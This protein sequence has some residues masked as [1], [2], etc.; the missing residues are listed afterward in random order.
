MNEDDSALAGI[1]TCSRSLNMNRPKKA[2]THTPR[3]TAQT[4]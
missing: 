4:P 1:G 2:E 3:I